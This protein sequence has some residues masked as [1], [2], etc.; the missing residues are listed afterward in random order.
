MGLEIDQE[1]REFEELLAEKRHKEMTGALKSVA[2]ALRSPK[3]DPELKKLMSENRDA[4]NIFVNTVKEIK[5]KES[6]VRV[7]IDDQKLL[8]AIEGFGETIGK[9]M[10]G[11]DKRLTAL[12]NKPKPTRLRAE[13]DRYSNEINYVT[14]EYLK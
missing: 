1:E 13:R 6:D 9:L 10:A 3:D 11:I 12:E 14:I 2:E 7:E 4:I 5:A 8:N